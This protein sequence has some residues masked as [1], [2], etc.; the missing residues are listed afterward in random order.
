MVMVHILS[1][2]LWEFECSFLLLLEFGNPVEAVC[3]SI[4]ADARPET[5][6]NG[7][8]A[9][10]LRDYP[11]NGIPMPCHAQSSRIA[12]WNR[13]LAKEAPGI[14]SQKRATEQA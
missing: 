1:L 6:T 8:S 2:A 14:L 4:N 7:S 10:F 5:K 11:D 3:L 13:A 9:T 12:E